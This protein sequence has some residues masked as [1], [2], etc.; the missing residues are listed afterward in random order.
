M[1]D[2]R[3]Y[4]TAL[5]Q[6]QRFEGDFVRMPHPKLN[7]WFSMWIRPRATIQQIVD[8]DPAYLVPVLAG[9]MGFS[10]GLFRASAK[11]LGDQLAWPWI[12]LIVA[13]FG[14]IGGIIG[15]YFLGGLIR[16]TGRWMGGKAAYVEVRAAI[17]WSCVP[18]I[19]ALILWIPMLAIFGQELFTSYMLRIDDDFSLAFILFGFGVFLL[20]AWIW[21]LVIF[22]K[23]LGQ[24]QG[25]SAWRALG[26]TTLSGLVMGVPLIIFFSF[27]EPA[28]SSTRATSS[29][30]TLDQI[31]TS[32]KRNDFS[33]EDLIRRLARGAVIL[34]P[35]ASGA[36]AS[37]R[38]SRLG[39]LPAL[40]A[41]V[42]WPRWKGESLPFIAQIDLGSQPAVLAEQGFPEEGLLL[43]FYEAFEQKA[44]GLDP[45][46]AGGFQVIYVP[47]PNQAEV[48][49][50]WP[51][52][53][54]KVA[55]FNPYPLAPQE[56][57]LLPPWDSLLIEDLH[58][59]EEKQEAY[60]Y[61]LDEIVDLEEWAS[62]MI[63]GGY[64]DQIQDDMTLDCELISAGMNVEDASVYEH[65]RVP[66]LRQK[67]HEWR[68]LIQIPSSEERGMM[69][70]DMG[71]LYFWIRE[72]D[73][74]A[75]RFDSSWMVMQCF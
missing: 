33:D 27:F 13:G 74:K 10:R 66:E 75:R 38:G 63:L 67:A 59:D 61:L 68:L 35:D 14:P 62:R 9:L 30:M 47:D 60:E 53:L 31:L 41:N 23:S 7:P 26:N 58:L 70:G 46:D 56:T 3:Y 40:P 71:C 43:F 69:W 72:E 37:P 36:E 21:S 20:T 28:T 39:G 5:F 11:N 44:M 16:W 50:E 49:A 52:D 8:T 51:E 57:V 18:S 12:I 4:P 19:W 64:P 25:F 1:I 29:T 32:A 22:L 48:V 42:P 45:K 54:P 73:L 6:Q 15:L 2:R 65:P 24:V 17:A 34:Q 55:R